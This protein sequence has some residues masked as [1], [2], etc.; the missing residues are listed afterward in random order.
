[1]GKRR[2]RRRWLRR[3]GEPVRWLLCLGAAGLLQGY[4]YLDQLGRMLQFGGMRPNAVAVSLVSADRMPPVLQHPVEPPGTLP[5]AKARRPEPARREPLGELT[6]AEAR[7]LLEEARL[8]DHPE[9][10]DP[11]AIRQT[12]EERVRRGMA[13]GAQDPGKAVAKAEALSRAVSKESANEIADYL[14]Y[15]N[16]EFVPKTPRPKGGFDFNDSTIWDL[17]KAQADDGSATYRVTMVDR[18]GRTHTFLVPPDEDPSQYD[19]VYGMLQMA[20]KNPAMGVIIRRMVLP[21]AARLAGSVRDEERKAARARLGPRPGPATSVPPLP[22]P[23]PP[24][25]PVPERK[26][27]DERES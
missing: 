20:R 27:E 3:G 13:A 8:A 6:E 9:A 17:V 12:I 21:M 11:D 26:A 23:A 7:K 1:M 10:M 14:G 15:Q 2:A 18:A 16:A 19:T 5:D 22:R 25:K 24:A 4:A